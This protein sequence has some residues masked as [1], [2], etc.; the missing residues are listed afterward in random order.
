MDQLT[1]SYSNHVSLFGVS[2]PRNTDKSIQDA[3]KPILLYKVRWAQLGS[4]GTFFDIL[5]LRLDGQT[6][7]NYIGLQGLLTDLDFSTWLALTY[8][9]T[10]EKV[11]SI[12]SD[13]N[14]FVTLRLPAD[15]KCNSASTSVGNY[16]LTSGTA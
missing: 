1:H 10:V 5:G 9:K 14:F 8:S 13:D 3:S 12:G 2:M 6:G 15:W 7:T 11:N 16:L 4:C